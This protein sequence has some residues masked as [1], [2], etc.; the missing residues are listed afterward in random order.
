MVLEVVPWR[1]NFNTVTRQVTSSQAVYVGGL[2]SSSNLIKSSFKKKSAP[3]KQHENP[4]ESTVERK[5]D[6]T[7]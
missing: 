4:E 1:A 2:V 3:D 7:N 5:T 6:D